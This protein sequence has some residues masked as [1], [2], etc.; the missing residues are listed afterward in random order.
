MY[1]DFIAAQPPFRRP[2][3][4]QKLHA[5]HIAT[6]MEMRSANIDWEIIVQQ[7]GVNHIHCMIAEQFGFDV[8]PP[9]GE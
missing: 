2:Q 7:T 3:P 8:Y 6:A 5:E 1:S 4:G 9:L